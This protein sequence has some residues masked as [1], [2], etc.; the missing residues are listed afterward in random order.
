MPGNDRIHQVHQELGD[1]VD[2]P[3]MAARLPHALLD[4]LKALRG[5]LLEA[6][7][8]N[9]QAN[10]D[11]GLLAAE[12]SREPNAERLQLIENH[13]LGRSSGRFIAMRK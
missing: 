11:G 10:S 6:M 4:R 8:T 9:A 1:I 2:D 3:C 5:M 7:N 13:S 12:L